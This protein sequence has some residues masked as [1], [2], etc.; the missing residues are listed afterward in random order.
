MKRNLISG[1]I[2]SL[3]MT[4]VFGGVSFAENAKG[5]DHKVG[6]EAKA[7]ESRPAEERKSAD[8]EKIGA[9]HGRGHGHKVVVHKHHHKVV[10]RHHH[11]H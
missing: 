5:P 1:I 8:H 9:R 7:H 6:T 3:A 10:R 11:H 4:G 2:V